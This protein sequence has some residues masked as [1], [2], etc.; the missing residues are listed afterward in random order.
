MKT[1]SDTTGASSV[2]AHS[3]PVGEENYMAFLLRLWR[4]DCDHPWHA[5]LIPV[6]AEDQ[7]IHFADLE[8]LLVFLQ[9]VR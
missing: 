7:V 3:V 4:S 9:S 5:S 8:A 2:N 1:L 6:G